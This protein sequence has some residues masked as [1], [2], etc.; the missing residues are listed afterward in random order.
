MFSLGL[1]ECKEGR[2]R[3]S[4]AAAASLGGKADQDLRPMLRFLDRISYPAWMKLDVATALS[5]L[6]RGRKASVVLRQK[7]IAVRAKS[8]II[9]RDV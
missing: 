7:V 9:K 2:Y 4:A 3:N 8:R 5:S 1:L 6:K